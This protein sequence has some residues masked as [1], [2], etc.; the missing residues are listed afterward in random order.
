MDLIL[1]SYGAA[2][3]KDNDTFVVIHSDGKQRIH[4]DG[5]KTGTHCFSEKVD[6]I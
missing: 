6:Y 2:L 1:N 4:P 3:T 5:L